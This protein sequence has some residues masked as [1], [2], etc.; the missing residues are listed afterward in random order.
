MIS[1]EIA[2]TQFV[3][4]TRIFR[5]NIY[6]ESWLVFW[7]VPS[8]VR[9]ESHS[10][11]VLLPTC[12]HDGRPNRRYGEENWTRK[13]GSETWRGKL[14]DVLEKIL[15]T[16]RFKILPL[17]GRVICLVFRNSEERAR[18]RSHTFT[19][20]RFPA[21]VCLR[22]VNF[23]PCDVFHYIFSFIW[24]FSF[25]L[26]I[27]KTIRIFA[28]YYKRIWNS[29]VFGVLIIFRFVIIIRLWF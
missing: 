14:N 12:R 10:R 11:I 29:L 5:A 3:I 8:I 19:L 16:W 7:L 1:V 4:S 18:G 22:H 13:T 24:R 23:E 27:N 2:C 28:P 9:C 21:C 25:I 6:C 20:N 26:I 17:H 15:L